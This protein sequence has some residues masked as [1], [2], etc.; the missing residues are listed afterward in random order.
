MLADQTAEAIDPSLSF[1]TGGC[2]ACCVNDDEGRCCCCYCACCEPRGISASYIL[3]EIPPQEELERE[4][5]EERCCCG[6]NESEEEEQGHCCC[7]KKGEVPVASASAT[8][9]V[10][11]AT[12]T[13]TATASA[14]AP[15]TTTTTPL[16]H[17][18]TTTVETAP[19]PEAAQ[20]REA[21]QA[22]SETQVPP[23]QNQE[24]PTLIVPSSMQLPSNPSSILHDV[25]IVRAV[26]DDGSGR[27]VLIAL[28]YSVC[29][30]LQTLVSVVKG[31]L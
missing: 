5:E 29:C 17:T 30:V 25:R 16:Q 10:P 3:G 8:V 18:T 19:V 31:T 11:A 20:Q 4:V 14:P 13:A 24:S 2:C 7:G 6:E 15:A 28:P 9:E 12:A 23:S 1:M 26:A 27:T 22:S 21:I